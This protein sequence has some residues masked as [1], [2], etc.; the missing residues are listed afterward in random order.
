MDRNSLTGVILIVI[1]VVGYN[2][3]FP[4]VVDVES[5][6]KDS[7]NVVLDK[8]VV[9]NSVIDNTPT[10][11]DSSLQESNKQA[12]GV[13]YPASQVSDDVVQI[14]NEKLALR[15]SSKGGRIISA[16]L[17][18]F[19]TS[20]SLPLNLIDRDSSQFNITFFSEGNRIINT[21]DLLLSSHQPY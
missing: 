9:D 14:E 16:I 7:V 3:L 2:M 1:I 20:D 19:Q 4:P 8:E 17:K 18:N 6:T 5:P 21:Q 10:L 12:F 13:F 15:I 11:S